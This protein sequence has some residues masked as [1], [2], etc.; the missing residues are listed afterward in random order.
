MAIFDRLQVLFNDA[1]EKT[2]GP[3]DRY[4]LRFREIGRVNPDASPR[5]FSYVFQASGTALDGG[6]ARMEVSLTLDQNLRKKAKADEKWEVSG[7]CRVFREIAGR[8]RHIETQNFTVMK[9]GAED[10]ARM[11]LRAFDG[12]ADYRRDT[13]ADTLG[14][15]ADWQPRRMAA[16]KAA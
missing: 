11:V 14:V 8:E 9:T 16:P 10:H 6:A 15:L 1:L 5:A 12:M 4:P 3:G 2:Y 7:C 13:V